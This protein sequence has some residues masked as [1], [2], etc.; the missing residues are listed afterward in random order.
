MPQVRRGNITTNAGGNGAGQD[1]QNSALAATPA[2]PKEKARR[3]PDGRGP[4]QWDHSILAQ[5]ATLHEQASLFVV[6][7]RRIRELG[8]LA[9]RRD[10]P[11]SES[12]DRRPYQL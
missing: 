7:S 2:P 3:L 10:R 6:I 1:I 12:A 8:P 5:S 4:G 11:A 9:I